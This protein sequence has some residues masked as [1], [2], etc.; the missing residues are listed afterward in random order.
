VTLAAG[1]ALTDIAQELRLG[2]RS[3]PASTTSDRRHSDIAP[4]MPKSL[5][6]DGGVSQARDDE[7]VRRSKTSASS[8]SGIDGGGGGGGSS[9]SSSSS[10]RDDARPRRQSVIGL[11]Q[12]SILRFPS[13]GR[14]R[15]SDSRSPIAG[16]GIEAGLSVEV[17]SSTPRGGSLSSTTLF[18]P[19][20]LLGAR[21]P[22]QRGGLDYSLD[23][24]SPAERAQ[25][26][27][28]EVRG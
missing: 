22:G 3:A 23:V 28:A 1:C 13:G 16:G 8:S 17:S 21:A 25:R 2:L 9:S 6:E 5:S 18:G 7:S 4:S 14:S 24:A 15:S 27:L 20:V 19:G 10:S 11:L 26:F 12:E